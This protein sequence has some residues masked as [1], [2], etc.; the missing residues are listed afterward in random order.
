[1][2]KA[3]IH[4]DIQLDENNVPDKIFWDASDNPNEGLND[5]QAV[6]IATWDRY[7]RAT[8]KLD[9]WTKDMEV[10]DM[11]QFYIEIMSGIAD[12]VTSATGD[13]KMAEQI[14][15]VCKIL[16]RNLKSELEEL[17]RNSK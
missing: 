2:K 12:S 5:T 4:F 15:D 13:K 14:H 9:L 3:E 17:Q 6:S 16:S 11:K 8:M 10:G 7:H 1:M